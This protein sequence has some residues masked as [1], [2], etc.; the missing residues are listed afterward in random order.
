MSLPASTTAP[1]PDAGTHAY[2]YNDS[3]DSH[4]QTHDIEEKMGEGA[5]R[6]PSELHPDDKVNLP[7][8]LY[9]DAR[10]EDKSPG[11][12]RVEA[13]ASVFTSWHRW[14]LFFFLF[15]VACA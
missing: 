4:T 9:A 15:I 11:V 14:L 2:S 13:I 6:P 8:D 1:A 3:H 10:V 7:G 12:L 5:P